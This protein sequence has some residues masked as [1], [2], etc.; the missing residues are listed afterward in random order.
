[1]AGIELVG[2]DSQRG[3][4][5]AEEIAQ[6]WTLPAPY[7]EDNLI[8]Q[9][10]LSSVFMDTLRLSGRNHINLSTLEGF[11]CLS[12]YSEDEETGAHCSKEERGFAAVMSMPFIRRLIKI[13]E[14]LRPALDQRGRVG[15]PSPGAASQPEIAMNN[16]LTTLLEGTTEVSQAD[17]LDIISGWPLK[18]PQL[19]LGPYSVFYD[20]V[21]LVWVHEWAHALC[22]HVVVANQELGISRLHEFSAERADAVSAD[23]V[24]FSSNEILQ[25]MEMHADEFAVRY[26]INEIFYGHDPMADI[27]G[28]KI[29]L[30]DRLLIFNT[31]CCVFAVTWALGE[32]QYA[33]EDTFYPRPSEGDQASFRITRSTHPPALVRYDRF[34]NF[35][36]ELTMLYG[37]K[38]GASG[39]LT[40]VDSLSF[41][42]LETLGK[43][44]PYFESLD[45]ST[46]LIAKTPTQKTIEAYETHLLRLGPFISRKLEH[47]GYVPTS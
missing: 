31:A 18:G 8:S 3:K 26:C 24:E 21:R 41:T 32:K 47:A 5:L 39:F 20:L 30:V 2:P 6:S 17:A 13:S 23:D 19:D 22:G 9:H 37:M 38:H 4:T 10:L 25:A 33:P 29:E 16:E 35:Q 40:S 11:R 14:L 28:P 46:P 43:V 45:A 15:R 27:A 1:M 44:S 7:R 36:R 34:R 12:Y 42:F